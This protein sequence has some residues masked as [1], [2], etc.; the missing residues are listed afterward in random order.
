MVPSDWEDG[1]I[2]KRDTVRKV[3]RVERVE[4][5]CGYAKA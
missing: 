5:G 4:F 2:V 1:N 3:E